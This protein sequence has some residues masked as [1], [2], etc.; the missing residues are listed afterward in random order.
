[1]IIMNKN[2]KVTSYLTTAGL[3][4]AGLIALVRDFTSFELSAE[5]ALFI[6]AVANLVIYNTVSFLKS[7][8]K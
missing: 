2:I 7:R 4:S 8:E 5:A 3:T 6:M 1:M